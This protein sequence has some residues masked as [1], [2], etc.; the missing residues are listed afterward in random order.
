MP[1]VMGRLAQYLLC[2]I[3]GGNA[4]LSHDQELA[5]MVSCTHNIALYVMAI[6]GDG[7]TPNYTA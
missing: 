5:F 6:V 7:H 1:K 3:I 2:P 4:H